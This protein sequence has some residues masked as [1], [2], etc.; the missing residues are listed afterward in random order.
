MAKQFVLG[1]DNFAAAELGLA[2][3]ELS[4]EFGNDPAM[5]ATI[6]REFGA[7]HLKRVAKASKKKGKTIKRSPLKKTKKGVALAYNPKKHPRVAARATVKKTV[8]MQSSESPEE[9]ALAEKVLGNT[10]AA[11]EDGDADAQAAVNMAEE[12]ALQNT[13]DDAEVDDAV[14]ESS[15]SD[16][17]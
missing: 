16:E 12:E 11:A 13:A 15:D 10:Y 6:Y 3:R 4:G 8:A 14:D 5:T 2:L 9:R 1:A 17:E 7:K